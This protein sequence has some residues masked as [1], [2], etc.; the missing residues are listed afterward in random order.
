MSTHKAEVVPVKL[1]RHPDA[2]SLSIVKVFG[3]YNVCVRTQDWVGRNKGIYIEPDFVVDSTRPE[4]AFLHN[5]KRD[6]ERIK[7]KRL[8]GVLSHGLLI[9][10]PENANIGDDYLEQLG[11]TRY[12]P[13]VEM[14]TGLSTS[15]PDLINVK[16]VGKYDLENWR[17]YCEVFEEGESVIVTEK[18]H[19]ANYRIVW[20]GD[21]MHVGSRT[22]WKQKD[23][24][25]WKVL[26]DQNWIEPL[27]KAHPGMV[28]YG[29]LAGQVKG[30]NYGTSPGKL[31][32]FLFDV[33]KEDGT[34]MDAVDFLSFVPQEFSAP[35]IYNGAYNKLLMESF[36]EGDSYLG[37]HIREGCVIKP[38]RE[39]RTHVG[40]KA[41]KLVSTAYLEK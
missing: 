16:C 19:G 32:L 30:F 25:W 6:K 22:Q 41:L 33:L 40:R 2:D 27:V 10:A 15:A 13:P 31:D 37:N 34:W 3:A 4:F 9:P 28:F 21:Q 5:G 8:R 38:Y 17:K 7:V 20:D 26:E 11:I 18:I 23:D 36:A 24:F 29:E 39:A 35:L 1:E 12:E 14:S